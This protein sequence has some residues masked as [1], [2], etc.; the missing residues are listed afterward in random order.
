M[1]RATIPSV[2]PP[3]ATAVTSSVVP[4][5]PI[6]D[7]PLPLSSAKIRSTAPRNLMPAGPLVGVELE[8]IDIGSAV[9]PFNENIQP[10]AC[11]RARRG[12]IGL[13]PAG[14]LAPAE[15]VTI[16]LRGIEEDGAR[17]IS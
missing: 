1:P 8:T 5:P 12:G 9:E 10:G 2:P 17:C 11:D 16:W 14:Y 3:L 15:P 4:P 7:Q 6:D 13:P